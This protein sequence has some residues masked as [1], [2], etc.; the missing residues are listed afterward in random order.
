MFTAGAIWRS[1]YRWVRLCCFLCNQVFS[2]G[3]LISIVNIIVPAVTYWVES[4]VLA[5][6]TGVLSWWVFRPRKKKAER[7]KAPAKREPALE[8]PRKAKATARL[9]AKERRDE[10]TGDALGQL[11][12]DWLSDN[13]A[14]QRE[15]RSRGE[16]D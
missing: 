8:D 10:I 13:L 9:R 1:D 12:D 14:P 15:P 4:L 7:T 2:I 6:G 3:L 16:D 5:G 11:T